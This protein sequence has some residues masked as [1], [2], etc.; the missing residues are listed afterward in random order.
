MTIQFGKVMSLFQK[1]SLGMGGRPFGGRRGRA[2]E[3]EKRVEGKRS[4]ERGGEGR[5][6]GGGGGSERKIYPQT[7]KK[8]HAGK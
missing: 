6:R 2:N 1:S 8:R 5:R 4:D 3:S 7:T